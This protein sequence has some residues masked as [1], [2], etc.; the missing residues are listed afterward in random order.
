MTN[1]G[2]ASM[3]K[4]KGVEMPTKKLSVREGSRRIKKELT[5]FL[6]TLPP[7]ERRSRLTAAK[8]IAA[9]IGESR[10]TTSRTPETAPTH[11]SASSPRE[12]F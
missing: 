6:L 1:A 3:I 9:K 10:A 11:L 7:D 4:E 8:R 5:A 12:G 2:F